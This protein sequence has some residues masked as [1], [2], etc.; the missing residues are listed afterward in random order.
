MSGCKVVHIIINMYFI[1]IEK[2][3]QDK[4]RDE[5]EEKKKKIMNKKEGN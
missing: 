2:Q 5:G 4:E 1:S 3:I